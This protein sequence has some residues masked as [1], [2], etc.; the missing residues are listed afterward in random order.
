MYD[1]LTHFVDNIFKQAWAHFLQIVKWFHLFISN[2]TYTFYYYS[3][4]DNKFNNF[5]YCYL[6]QVILFNINHL[7]AERSGYKYCYLTLIILFN[8][9]HLFAHSLMVPSIAML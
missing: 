9:I 8:T 3:F 4:V 6:I 5:N 7:F 1:L 2:M